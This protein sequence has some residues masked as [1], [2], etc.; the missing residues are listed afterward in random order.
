MEASLRQGLCMRLSF[1]LT[2]AICIL[3]QCCGFTLTCCV[4][5]FFWALNTY[6]ACC[7]NKSFY[8]LMQGKCTK[9]SITLTEFLFFC[10][11]KEVCIFDILIN[12]TY[13]QSTLIS[14]GCIPKD[15]GFDQLIKKYSNAFN[16]S[17]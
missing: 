4:G 1:Q 2:N 17:K 14:C 12:Y 11:A 5:F 3:H 10:L 9:I 15:N 6:H 7:V 16:A 13:F 8:T